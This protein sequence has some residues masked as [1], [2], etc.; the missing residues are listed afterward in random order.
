[1][2]WQAGRLY[3][4]NNSGVYE[5]RSDAFGQP[6]TPSAP[7][8]IASVATRQIMAT[9]PAATGATSYRLFRGATEVWRGTGR[10]GIDLSPPLNTNNC[11]QVVAENVEG[12]SAW[13]PAACTTITVPTLDLDASSP[14]T[15]YDALTD[16]VILYRYLFGLT[17]SMLTTNALGSAAT[18]KDP[19]AIGSYIDG[20]RAELDIDGN[21]RVDAQTDGLLVLRYLFGLRGD[22]LIKGAYDPLGARNTAPA[23]ESYIQSLMP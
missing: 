13:S 12:F 16:G 19:I 17:G 6:Q 10:S 1:L 21:G 2:K 11:Y 7:A 8:L 22:A 4:A 23:I 3:V 5:L 20:I 9:W 14:A 15:K 18:R